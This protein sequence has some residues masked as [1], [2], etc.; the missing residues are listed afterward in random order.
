M[1]KPAGLPMGNDQAL[2]G[3]FLNPELPTELILCHSRQWVMNR[4]E[5]G[6]RNGIIMRIH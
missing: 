2:Q 4:Q 6:R 3:I 1:G 5:S